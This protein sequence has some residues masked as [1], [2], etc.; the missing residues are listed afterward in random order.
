[1]RTVVVNLLALALLA[2]LALSAAAQSHAG[3][4]R[5]VILITGST[6]VDQGADGLTDLADDRGAGSPAS[7]HP[8]DVRFMQ[9]MI[10]HHAQALIL[11]RMVAERTD[12][13]DLNL[14]AR[15]IER[16][17]DDEIRLM[18]RWL[19]AR[20]EAAPVVNLY[21]PLDHGARH[22]HHG[23]AGHDAGHDHAGMAG[24]L[25]DEQ[26]D[27]LA[28]ARGLEFERLF[29]EYMIYHHEGALIMVEELFA[30]PGAGQ[31][32]DIFQFAS[33]VDSDQRME[34]IRMDG[35]LRALGTT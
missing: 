30:T 3:Q 23:H 10:V 15:R 27:R 4:D 5:Q 7:A 20:G 6:D 16:S 35:L 21:D 9:H 8:A 12:R 1:M 31:D 29:L 14:L 18:T 17:Q 19:E 33:H 26:L 32:S 2:A 34:I 11:A 24:M 13:R 22:R 25:S 28:A